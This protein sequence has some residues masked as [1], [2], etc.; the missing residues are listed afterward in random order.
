MNLDLENI[1]IKAK[2]YKCFGEQPQGFNKIYPV[3]LLIGRNNSGKSALIDIIEASATREPNEN[4]R[5]SGHK[6]KSPEI[7]FT[8]R[9]EKSD[10]EGVFR[11]NTRGGPLPGNHY[12]FGKR[13]IDSEMTWTIDNGKSRFIS[14]KIHPY[15]V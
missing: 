6:G 8:A 15:Q 2:N 4:V 12:E 14:I 5:G 13:W 1:S 10:I 7:H 3:N 9:L 11:R